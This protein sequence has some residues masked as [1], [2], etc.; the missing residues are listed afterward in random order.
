MRRQWRLDHFFLFVGGSQ[1]VIIIIF[2]YF[3]F[4]GKWFECA[5]DSSSSWK[6]VK[7]VA[8]EK[9]QLSIPN[10]SSLAFSD[11]ASDV[12]CVS[13]FHFFLSQFVGS[14]FIY[15]FV[16]SFLGCCTVCS[17]RMVYICHCCCC[18]WSACELCVSGAYFTVHRCK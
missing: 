12:V 11:P 9:I 16:T 7:V 1:L 18:C 17:C 6:A 4:Y 8:R 15:L 14:F 10:A 3:G 5:N 2:D 13:F